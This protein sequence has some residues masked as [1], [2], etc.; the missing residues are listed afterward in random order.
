MVGSARIVCG[1]PSTKPDFGSTLRLST[2]SPVAIIVQCA[3]NSVLPSMLSTSTRADT[4]KESVFNPGFLLQPSM[5]WFGR[6]SG[7]MRLVFCA[8]VNVTSTL[9]SSQMSKIISKQNICNK[10]VKDTLV[11]A[12]ENCLKPR[13]LSKH[14]S[15]G[16]RATVQ[17]KTARLTIN[18]NSLALVESKVI[19]ESAEGG[20][21]WRC[22][23][24]TYTSQYLTNLRGHIETHHVPSQGHYCQIC[25]KFCP[26]KNALRMHTRRHKQLQ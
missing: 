11:P 7:R 26:T 18:C 13:T 14:T 3:P 6:R 2:S 9:S 10:S 23:D 24:C 5:N 17:A 1:P 8:V 20:S 19:K 12:V 4:T 21:V 15:R 16:L 25:S 22:A